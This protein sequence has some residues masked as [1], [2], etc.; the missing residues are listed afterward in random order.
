MPKM[1]LEAY[2]KAVVAFWDPKGNSWVLLSKQ[3]YSRL[4]M[5]GMSPLRMSMA[6]V[7]QAD[8][9]IGADSGMSHVAEGLG[10]KHIALYST[11]P[12]WTRAKYYKFQTPIDPGEN[13]PEFYTFNLGLGDPLRVQEG[14]AGLT[15]RERLVGELHEA[16][17]GAAEAAEAL[18]T[19]QEGAKYELQALVA[20]RASWER[21]QSKAL[22]T[23]KPEHVMEKVK[24][25][26]CSQS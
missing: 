18:N 19:D 5:P 10:V 7:A 21:M 25:V 11:V 13:N 20:K 22:S 4:E 15:E 17:A 12:A 23:I 26:L 16:G 24:K 14:I 8:L 3:G 2:P 6:L 9:F 1:L